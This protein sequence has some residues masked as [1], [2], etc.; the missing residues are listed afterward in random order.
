ML[1][2]FPQDQLTRYLDDNERAN[3][4]PNTLRGPRAGV[5]FLNSPISDS[6]ISQH[7]DEQLK[8]ITKLM[9]GA[10][11]L[12]FL[13]ASKVMHTNHIIIGS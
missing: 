13:V 1:K 3:T 8:Q 4:V 7:Y 5:S 11:K 2:R 12:P 9:K 10:N 6:E